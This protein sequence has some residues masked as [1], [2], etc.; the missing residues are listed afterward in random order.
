MG[1]NQKTFHQK[2]MDIFCNYTIQSKLSERTALAT[3]SHLDKTLFE[4][5]IYK[6]HSRKCPAQVVDAASRGCLFT[7]ASTV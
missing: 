6:N 7:E 2:S 3:Y 5:A 1:A 4:F